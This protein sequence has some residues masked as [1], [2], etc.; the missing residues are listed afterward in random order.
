MIKKKKKLRLLNIAFL[1][2]GQLFK[3][4]LKINTQFKTP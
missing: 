1:T 3:G 2:T 4:A